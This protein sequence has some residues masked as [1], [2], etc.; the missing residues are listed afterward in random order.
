MASDVFR[1]CIPALLHFATKIGLFE[2]WA[3]TLAATER[4]AFLGVIRARF[5]GIEEQR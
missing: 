5:Y 2:S 1:G 4:A 3:G